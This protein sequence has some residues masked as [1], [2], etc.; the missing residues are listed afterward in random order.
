M[1]RRRS[2]FAPQTPFFNGLFERN[3][4]R[5]LSRRGPQ[6]QLYVFDQAFQFL[7]PRNLTDIL[8]QNQNATNFP[9][10]RSYSY[11]S[12][13]RSPSRDRRRR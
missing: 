4:S 6:V 2:E 9:R 10:S 1:G 3:R 7:A 11:Y 8:S 12:D 13:S 5:N